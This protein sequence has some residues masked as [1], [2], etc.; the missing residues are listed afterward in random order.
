MI[1][2]WWFIYGFWPLLYLWDMAVVIDM[3]A[4]AYGF[5]Y[6]YG[7]LIEVQAMGYLDILAMPI[8]QL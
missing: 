3:L 6:G 2:N 5:C 4:T 8:V 1:I 7:I